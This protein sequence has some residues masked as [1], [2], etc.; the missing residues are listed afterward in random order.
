MNQAQ[1]YRSSPKWPFVTAFTMA[2]AIHLSAVAFASRH[3]ETPE[4]LPRPEFTDVYVDEPQSDSTPVPEQDT[5]P[6][7]APPT[8][9]DD[10]VESTPPPRHPDK[11]P[12]AS[13]LRPPGPAGPVAFRNV[14]ANMLSAPRP[15]Y[16]YEAR[17]RHL[18]G[19]GLAI[20]SVDPASG[21]V[22]DV[23]MEQSTGE[24]I[25]DH[26]AVSAFGRWRFTPS[27]E[28]RRIHRSVYS[29][30]QGTRRVSRLPAS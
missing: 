6:E 22:V 18:T 20:V 19:A 16:P 9:E 25:L 7:L 8:T 23:Q 4:S 15:E 1:L 10:F 30:L 14:K 24:M 13:P 5:S 17:R 27:S 29:L 2:A 12:V 3:R 11:R 28:K 21:A 26:S